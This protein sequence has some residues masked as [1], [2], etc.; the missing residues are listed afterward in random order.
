MNP[1]LV[2]ELLEDRAPTLRILYG[3]AT[4]ANTVLV[5][6]STVA[7]VL[8][9]LSPVANGDYVAVLATGADRLI[10]GCVGGNGGVVARAS[11]ITP[12]GAL[13]GLVGIF[14]APSFVAPAGRR[15]RITTYA[16]LVTQVG[17]GST[18]MVIY[19]NIL[20]TQIRSQTIS[21]AG[22]AAGDYPGT[23]MVAEDAPPAGTT[24]YVM[25]FFTNATSFDVFASAVSPYGIIVED[26]G[27]A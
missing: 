27:T 18:E 21:V 20:G 12:S 13:S 19:R 16:P 3:V 6:G 11:K 22:S 4:G 1:S 7:V 10:L 24:T 23:T 14:S 25:Y 15:Y 8:P 17:V 26:I 5:A 9:A 2:Q